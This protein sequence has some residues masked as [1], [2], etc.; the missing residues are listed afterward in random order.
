MDPR[1]AEPGP[2]RPATSEL[3]R[4]AALQEATAALSGAV[5]PADVA[6]VVLDHGIALLG[7]RGGAV[8]LLE[9]EALVRLEV[10]GVEDALVRAQG[11]VTLSSALP[12]AEAARTGRAVWLTSQ[13]KL[14]A[15]YPGLG[16]L[17]RRERIGALAAAAL[18]ARGRTVG[19]VSFLFDQAR[20]FGPADRQFVAGLADACAIALERAQLFASERELRARAEE[21]AALLQRFDQLRLLVDQVRDYAIFMLD[22]EGVVRTWNRGAERIKGYRAEE[23][24]GSHFSRFYPEA[25]VLAGKPARMLERAAAEGRVEDEGL[26]VRKDG[27]LFRA[28]VVITALRDADGELRG[29]A[30]VTRDVTERVEAEHER[31]RLARAEEATRAR[32]QFLAIASHELRTPITA[33]GLQA[34]ALLRLGRRNPEAPIAAFTPRLE[35]L[36]RQGSRLTHLVQA[37][38]DV[39]QL[40]AGRLAL[41]RQPVDL[42]AVVRE[43]MERWRDVLARAGCA[44]DLRVG[45]SL[46]GRW[47]RMRLEQVIDNLVANAVKFGAGRPV[48]VSAGT[49]GEHVRLEVR[50]HG[51][52]ISP[53]DQRRIFER[54]ERAVPHTHYGGFGLGLWIVRN[55]VQA[56]GGVIRVSSEPGQGSRFE[57]TLPAQAT[58]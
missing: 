52:G 15:R 49:D 25:D 22:R 51:I 47:D 4:L 53:E 35:T 57:V 33:L 2:T 23:I 13:R 29:F 24:V 32:D 34:E 19:T 6:R 38:L 39:T 1:S 55:I 14:N 41:H 8:T 3:R 31:V 45:A 12:A 50:D 44:L 56:H 48:E 42:A 21:T 40:T 10:R 17:V 27:S 11:Q 46:P 20:R 16:E 36:K 54:F 26:R 58:G 30:K 37:L 43:A 9:G 7:A 28:D 18:Q 5:T